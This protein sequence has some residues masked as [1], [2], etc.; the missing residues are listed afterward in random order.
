MFSAD[1]LGVRPYPVDTE[2][3]AGV[4]RRACRCLG[5]GHG[6]PAA[7]LAGLQPCLGIRGVLA[8]SEPEVAC[9]RRVARF[10][11]SQRTGVPMRRLRAVGSAAFVV[12]MV[13]A[14]GAGPAGATDA[15]AAYRITEFSSGLSAG[16]GSRPE[17][18]IQTLG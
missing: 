2:H 18:T 1:L 15:R 14:S 16:S 3:V 12:A 17:Q 11:P 7:G 10:I 6:R 13:V 8:V 9:C 5:L 4:C